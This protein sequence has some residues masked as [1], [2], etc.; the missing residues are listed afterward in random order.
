MFLQ[1]LSTFFPTGGF[2]WIDPK[3]LDLNKDTS[4]SSKRCVLKVDLEYPKELQELH[5]D[6][7]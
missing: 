7:L 6:F 4:N 3:E 5:N 1:W 2:T